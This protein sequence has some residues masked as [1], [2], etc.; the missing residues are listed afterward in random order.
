MYA[1]F[2]APLQIV[3][4]INRSRALLV[5]VFRM[6]WLSWWSYL[7][8]PNGGDNR[9]MCFVSPYRI[10]HIHYRP[11][12]NRVIRLSL[13]IYKIYNAL[14][15]AVTCGTHASTH[16][17]THQHTHAHTHTQSTGSWAAKAAART[18]QW[19]NHVR[20]TWTPA[21]AR[22]HDSI[23]NPPCDNRS[24]YDNVVANSIYKDVSCV[25]ATRA[26][27]ERIICRQ[28]DPD[29]KNTHA[30]TKK[31]GRCHTKACCNYYSVLRLLAWLLYLLHLS[32]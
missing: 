25:C 32:D 14:F 18:D 4:I 19:P 15:C 2:A 7:R 9:S 21:N 13:R 17:H 20:G 24:T 23:T 16:T 12:P 27:F 6:H 22:A 1:R 3:F 31:C 29:I 30:C 5:C 8:T 10:E 26:H 28:P 11:N